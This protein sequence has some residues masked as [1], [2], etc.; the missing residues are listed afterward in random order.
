MTEVFISDLHLTEG[1]PDITRGFLKFLETELVGASSLYILGDFFELWI[2]DDHTT[3]FNQTIIDALCAVE[4]PIYMMHGNRD[5]L[6]G[7]QFCATVGATLLTDPTVVELN[8]ERVLLM[9]GDSLCI[10]DTEYMKAR[11]LLRS[12]AFQADFLS[13]PTAERL[14]FAQGARQQSQAHTKE[15]AMA[16]MD[17]NSSEVVRVMKAASVRTLIH[18]H[19]H[20]PA[21]HAVDLDGESGKRIVLG[22]WT[23]TNGWQIRADHEGIALENFEY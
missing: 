23:S 6:L 2:G 16:I 4:V 17:V 18:G 10:D 11:G 3:P 21:T 20:R 14:A 12:D 22:D 8:G 15:T 13:K 1:E 7:E 19:T 5:F 9:H